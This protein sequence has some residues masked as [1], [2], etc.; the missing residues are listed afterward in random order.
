M[1]SIYEILDMNKVLTRLSDFADSKDGKSLCLS[2]KKIDN[3]NEL[4]KA[5]NETDA[6]VSCLKS[7]TAPTFT[8][9]N[10]ISEAMVRLSKEASLNISELLNISNCLDLAGKL[11]SY[12]NTKEFNSC[13]DIYFNSLD[14]LKYENDEIKRV[15]VSENE[16]ADSASS[17]LLAIRRKK[18]LLKEKIHTTAN[19]LLNTY[20]QYLQEPVIANKDGA[21]CISYLKVY[22]GERF[23]PS[24]ISKTG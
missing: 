22:I 2:L 3:K 5:I 16:I 6:A 1:K 19:R 14:P 8:K 10:D 7:S 15:I 12:R 17:I 21:I 4:Y 11:I 9:L 23:A 13:L 20:G 24:A 18:M